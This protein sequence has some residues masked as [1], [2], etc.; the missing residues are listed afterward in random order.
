MSSSITKRQKLKA[1]VYIVIE[2]KINKKKSLEEF[3]LAFFSN[4]EK[5]RVYTKF[6]FGS[7]RFKKKN[8][9]LEN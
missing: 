1:F 5:K 6:F 8:K 2:K 7:I 3:M 9:S 4:D